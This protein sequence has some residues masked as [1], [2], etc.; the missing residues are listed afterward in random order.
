M[1][2]TP[3]KVLKS[4]A[5]LM[6]RTP[7]D[8]A[9]W[10]ARYQ[11]TT[12]WLKTKEATAKAGASAQEVTGLGDATREPEPVEVGPGGARL[13][14][15]GVGGPEPRSIARTQATIEAIEA[16]TS[17]HDVGRA[18]VEESRE[19]VEAPPDVG[20]EAAQP[21]SQPAREEPRP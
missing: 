14:V 5:A 12:E 13:D 3:I 16:E 11:A 4:G 21:E 1:A 9:S 8:D 19:V 10:V 15:P 20:K 18:D 2:P 6:M 17:I 7:V